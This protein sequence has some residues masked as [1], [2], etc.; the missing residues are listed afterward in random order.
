MSYKLLLLGQYIPFEIIESKIDRKP[1][2]FF[3]NKIT[4]IVYKDSNIDKIL[5]DWYKEYCYSVVKN[6]TEFYSES[7]KKKPRE[8]KIKN[9]KT[10]WGSCS[11]K[12]RLNFCWKIILLPIELLNYIVIHEMCHLVHF[13]H[14]KNFWSCLGEIIPDYNE[15]IKEIK[16]WEKKIFELDGFIKHEKIT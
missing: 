13:N 1:K 5:Y 7:I 16:I 8:I 10:I 12:N 3:G 6:R 9:Q 4:L 14:S 11:S 15:R 2:I